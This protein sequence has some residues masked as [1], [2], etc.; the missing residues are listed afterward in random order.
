MQLYDEDSTD[1]KSWIR[2]VYKKICDGCK[3]K[4]LCKHNISL[5]MKLITSELTSTEIKIFYLKRLRIIHLIQYLIITI[6]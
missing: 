3:M 5:L 6:E 1:V 2:L 4:L